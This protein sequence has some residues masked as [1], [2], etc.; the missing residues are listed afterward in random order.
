MKPIK[1][2]IVHGGRD[3]EGTYYAGRFAR[4][5]LKIKERAQGSTSDT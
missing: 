2:A 3:Y 5:M 1:G 4:Y